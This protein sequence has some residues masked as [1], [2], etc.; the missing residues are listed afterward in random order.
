MLKQNLL[1]QSQWKLLALLAG[2]LLSI[3]PALAQIDPSTAGSSVQPGSV[4]NGTLDNRNPREVLYF[5][6]SRGEVIRL[7]LVATSGDLDPVLS[8]FDNNG[9]LVF[10]RDDSRSSRDVD[11]TLTLPADMRY[12]VVLGRFA[13]ALGSTSGNYEFTMER[14]GLLSQQGTTLR[15][16]IPV[17]NTISDLQPQVFYTFRALRGEIVNIDLIR[18][19]GTLDPYLQ[20]VDSERFLIAQNDDANPDTRNA[21]IENL[22]IEEDG[23]YIVIATRYGESSGTSAGSFVLTLSEAANSGIGNSSLIPATILANQPIEGSIDN[24]VFQRYYSFEA[25]RDDLISI[26]MDQIRG[27][28]DAYLMLLNSRGDILIENDDGGSGRNARIDNFRLPASGRYTIVAMRAGGKDGN[29]AGDYRLQLQFLGNAFE[30]IPPEIP[31]L[32]Y[33]TIVTDTISLDDGQ[34]LFVFWGTAGEGVSIGMNR[35]DGDLDP[36]LELL[37]NRQERLVRDDDGGGDK[38]A[39]IERFTLPYTGIYYINATRYSGSQGT[40]NTT[41]SYNLIFTQAFEP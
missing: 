14:V 22:L 6:G 19:S 30:G 5:D 12:Y 35:V 24:N 15:Y 3:T 33:G 16:D 27:Q 18:S 26:T 8:V 17:I 7:S 36:V 13:Y 4:M 41:G 32:L 25:Q 34:S 29:S 20:I 10:L 2:L 21:R 37:N 9:E 40:N 31:R 39:R 28:I 1:K 38:N 11:V 23:T